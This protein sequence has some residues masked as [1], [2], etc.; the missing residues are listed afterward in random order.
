[1]AQ[2]LLLLGCSIV[3]NSVVRESLTRVLI[4]H[5]L[6]VVCVRAK[7]SISRHYV[8]LFVVDTYIITIYGQSNPG[9]RLWS[10]GVCAS[11]I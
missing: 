8:S 6:S 9:Q 1:M 5:S 7:Y 4:G 2:G 11:K 10:Y 3:R